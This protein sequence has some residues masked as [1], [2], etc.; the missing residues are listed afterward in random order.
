MNVQ[1]VNSTNFKAIPIAKININGIKNQYKLYEITKNDIG[2]LNN[3]YKNLDLKTL[4]PNLKDYEYVAWDGV[5]Q[6][7]VEVAVKN[8]RKTI[9]ET[10]DGKLCGLLNYKEYP[11]KFHVNY[12]ATVPVEPKTKVPFAG[13]IL[14]NEFFRRLLDS[15]IDKAELNALKY[16]AFS[17]I[18]KYIKLGFKSIGGDNQIESMRIYR[19]NIIETFKKQNKFIHYNNEIEKEEIFFG[20]NKKTGSFL[21]RLPFLLIKKP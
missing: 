10:L 8:G 20:D 14:F 6:N 19:E 21:N 15:C 9:M 5:I 11:L 2:F 3:F 4:M 7:L 13:Q 18:T 16:S 1:P 12:V 17:P